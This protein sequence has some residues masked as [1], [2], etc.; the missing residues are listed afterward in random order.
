MGRKRQKS[1]EKLPKY[2]YLA[3]GRYIYRTYLGN[4]VYGQEIVIAPGDAPLSK[5][6]SEYEKISDQ[7]G[8]TL[9]WIITK[10]LASEQFTNTS[11]RTQ[12]NYQTYAKNL[13]EQP[14][15]NGLKF[16]DITINKISQ[17]T[18]R[19]YLDDKAAK[20]SANRHIAFLKVIFNWGLERYSIIKINP[21]IGVR[22]YSEKARERYIEDWEYELVRDLA[23]VEYIPIFMEIAYLCR[24]RW[25]EIATLKRDCISDDGLYLTRSKGSKDEITLWTPRLRLAVDNALQFNEARFS[26]YLIH[27]SSGEPIQQSAFTSAWRRVMDNAL[28][29]G[30]ADRFTFHDIKAKGV[31]DHESKHSGHK[32]ESMKHV[33]DRKI[34]KVISTK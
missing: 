1:R 25:S 16:G 7:G 17:R 23:S 15:A 5:V 26:H 18:I 4:G 20:V 11:T 34:N 6:Y 21:C 29:N 3:K 31:S 33:Y 19:K 8:Y 13:I 12:K 30:L 9:K 2:V 24:A 14:L 28:K 22:L 27:N 32:T 10:Y